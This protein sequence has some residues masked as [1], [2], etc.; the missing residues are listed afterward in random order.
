METP[1]LDIDY[2]F[3]GPNICCPRCKSKDII[4][5]ESKEGYFWV[6][7]CNNCSYRGKE[8]DSVGC[9]DKREPPHGAE[10]AM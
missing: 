5:K 8:G 2:P 4:L 6:Y 1:E 10:D 7:L 3:E 9:V